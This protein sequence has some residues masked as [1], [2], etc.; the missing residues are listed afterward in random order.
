MEQCLCFSER[1]IKFH[2]SNSLNSGSICSSLCRVCLPVNRE[3][4][5][6][7]LHPITED[8]RN[9]YTFPDLFLCIKRRKKEKTELFLWQKVLWKKQWIQ[10]FKFWT[11]RCFSK[12]VPMP[13]F[14]TLQQRSPK[15]PALLNAFQAQLTLVWTLKMDFK[16]SNETSV[17]HASV[18]EPVVK[19][20]FMLPDMI[21]FSPRL[22]Q[23]VPVQLKITPEVSWFFSR[24]ST[25]AL[26]MG[27]MFGAFLCVM[28]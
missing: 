19:S 11:G 21:D 18:W 13:F 9:V 22:P 26:L 14:L 7:C 15:P 12:D 27:K 17:W 4:Q 10:L 2:L 3:M 20:K 1:L 6:S 23:L 8:W 24:S 16:W 5:L 28:T 25:V